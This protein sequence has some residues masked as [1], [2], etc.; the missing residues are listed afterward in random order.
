M[1]FYPLGSG[2]LALAYTCCAGLE[3]TAR[4]GQ[5]VYTRV[6]VLDPQ[7][8]ARF[9]YNPFDVMRSLLACTGHEPDLQPP[10]ELPL[11]ELPV[12]RRS[13]A[14]RLSECVGQVGS[15]WLRCALDHVLDGK[16]VVLVGDFP[17]EALVEAVLL[18]LPGP[19]RA[20][21]S[22]AVGLRYSLGRGFELSAVSGDLAQLQQS[23][24]GHAIELLRPA[25]GRS[26]PTPTDAAWGRMVQRRWD[27]G[28]W[29]E[30]RGL[31]S[32]PY[33]DCSADKL[34]VYGRLCCR[35]DELE[36]LDC[37]KLIAVLAEHAGATSPDELATELT[38]G[39]VT[40]VLRRLGDEM[41]TA[42]IEELRRH[43]GAVV[44]LWR[45]SRST[46]ACLAPLVGAMLKRMTRLAPLAAAEAGS[47]IVVSVGA[48]P[49]HR[50][51]RQALEDLLDHLGEWLQDQPADKVHL[52]ETPL[53]RWPAWGLFAG[54]L[55]ALREQ[56]AAR[57][58]SEPDTASTGA[59]RPPDDIRPSEVAPADRRV[60]HSHD[61]R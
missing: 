18:G 14:G 23:L 56:I 22:F 30:L 49:D 59:V 35:R 32:R 17:A 52:L 53:R 3:Q 5:R 24:R 20:Q 13:D 60:Y 7:A 34:N 16:P 43:W 42:P 50:P 39:L 28:R 19:L 58:D 38:V 36:D 40:Q 51:L 4:G 37:G 29:D 25:A 57:A 26:A 45:R 27:A 44:N 48:G 47:K 55:R 31:T 33:A 12:H 61:E 1:S 15:G 21:R 11:L 6:L 10:P 8:F 2:R 41:S 9:G 54:R 46:A